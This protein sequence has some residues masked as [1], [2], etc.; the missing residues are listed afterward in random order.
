MV[1]PVLNIGHHLVGIGAHRCHL[2]TLNHRPAVGHGVVVGV[3][4]GDLEL[5][6]GVGVVLIEL[7]PGLDGILMGGRALGV[8]GGV[9]EMGIAVVVGLL[10]ALAEHKGVSWA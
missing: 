9:D 5:V 10:I 7:L 6:L 4:D 2:G 8:D 3:D 1:Q